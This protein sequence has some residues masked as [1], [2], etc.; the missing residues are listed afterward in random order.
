MGV[1]PPGSNSYFVFSRTVV[2]R[3]VDIQYNSLNLP[4]GLQFTN[5]NT[6]NYVYDASGQKLSVT[7]LTAVAGVVIPMTNV[8]TPLAP[9]QISSTFKTDYCG[10]VIYENGAVSKILTDEGYITFTGATPVYHYYLKDHQGNNRVVINQAG[11]VEQV[12]HYYPFGGLMGESTSGGVQPYKYN[13]KELDRVH[14]LDLFDYGARFYDPQIGRWQVI[15]PNTEQYFGWSPYNYVTNNPLNLIDPDGRSGEV[16]IDKQNKT[17]TVTSN[18]ILYG[19]AG[20]AALAKSTAG[21]IQKQWNAAGGTVSIGGAEYRVKFVVNGSYNANLKESDVTGNKDIKNNYFKVVES[22]IDISYADGLGSNTGQFLLK[23]IAA[24]G[25]T[26]EAHEFGHG[27]GAVQGTA[28]GHPVDRDLRGDG[29]PGI[30][31]ARGTIVDPQYQYDPKAKPGE[32]GGTLNPDKR[33]VTQQD[34]NYLNLDKLKYDKNGKANLGS[35]S[36]VYH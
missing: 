32:K 31:N 27:W 1:R 22:G 35:L 25:S 15:D 10:N 3:I 6:T 30:M 2:K 21:D 7:H 13:G 29:Q 28:D 11:T 9:A 4:N 26:T 36:N 20:S 17:V 16:V 8:M 12:T 34:I 14:G 5:G 23:N 19:S 33:K 24:D 18:L